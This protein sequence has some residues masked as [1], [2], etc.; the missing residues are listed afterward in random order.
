LKITEF[1]EEIAACI[2]RVEE[3]CT[4]QT[5]ASGSLESLVISYLTT[6]RQILEDIIFKLEEQLI[7]RAEERKSKSNPTTETK[8]ARKDKREI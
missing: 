3:S 6:R 5:E 2:F 4:L 1:S 7:L 8:E